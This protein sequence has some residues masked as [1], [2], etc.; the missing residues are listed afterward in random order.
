MTFFVTTHSLV[1]LFIHI[2]FLRVNVIFILS[3][4]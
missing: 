4:S 2:F 3:S 1:F